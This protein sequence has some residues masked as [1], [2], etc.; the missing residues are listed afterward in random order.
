MQRLREILKRADFQISETSHV[1]CIEDASSETSLR[2]LRSSQRRLSVA[3]ETVSLYFET[4]AFFGYL[5]IYLHVFK[6]F[7]NLIFANPIRA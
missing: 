6:Y 1:R 5:L 7:A 3:S 2:F 4:E